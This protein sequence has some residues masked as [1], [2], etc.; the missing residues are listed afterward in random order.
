MLPRVHVG[1]GV[2][3]NPSKEGIETLV[4]DRDEDAEL[5][6]TRGSECWD[7]DAVEE[8]TT[9]GRGRTL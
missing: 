5:E 8:P 6:R 4:N 3:W 7:E 1:G 9:A 2:A